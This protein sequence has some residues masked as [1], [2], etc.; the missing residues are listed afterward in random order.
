MRL[1]KLM[2]NLGIATRSE[3]KK[4]VRSGRVTLNGAVVTDSSVHISDSDTVELDG[5]L[6]LIKDYIYLLMDKP[7]EVLTAM[8][9]KRLNCV[10]DYISPELKAKKISPV[11]RLDYHTTGLLI[12]T[13]DG[14]FAHRMT[15]PKYHL[16]KEYRILYRG[17]A[18]TSAQVTE[19]ASGMQLHDM[20]EVVNLKPAELILESDIG[21]LHCCQITISEGKTHQIRRMISSWGCEVIELRRTRIGSLVLDSAVL[22][23]DSINIRELTD[24]EVNRLKSELQL[25]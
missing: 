2:S 17:N 4:I 3:I 25:I 12:L 7:D 10:G 6:L 9:D 22:E 15:S 5:S 14:E 21:E 8:E 16:P 20:N 24:E 19:A 11:G 18:L 13:N 1:D 23:D